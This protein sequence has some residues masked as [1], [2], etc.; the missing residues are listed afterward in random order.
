MKRFFKSVERDGSFKRLATTRGDDVNS[1]AV[2]GD[3][4]KQPERR[5]P[6][7]FMSWNTNSFLLR[8]K[9]NREEVLALLGRLDP[10]V[11]AIQVSHLYILLFCENI[12]SRQYMVMT[13]ADEGDGDRMELV[14]ALSGTL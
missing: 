5:E 11:I 12:L 13:V 14:S 2:G 4:E 6:T 9:N 10:D 3:P 1:A 7:K 8:L